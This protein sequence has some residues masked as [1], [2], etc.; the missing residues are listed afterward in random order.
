M[1]VTNHLLLSQKPAAQLLGICPFFS[2]LHLKGDTPPIIS[3][4]H[5][6]N[7][8]LELTDRAVTRNFT[9]PKKPPRGS[10][11]EQTLGIVLEIPI[12]IRIHLG[13]DDVHFT[14]S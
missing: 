14:K 10:G 4:R 1:T 6:S 5:A 7:H 12:M 11:R 2:N 13:H 8:H 9:M 3:R